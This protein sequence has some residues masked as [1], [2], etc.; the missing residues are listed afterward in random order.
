MAKRRGKRKWNG[1][2]RTFPAELQRVVDF[3]EANQRVSKVI[4]GEYH[5]SRGGRRGSITGSGAGLELTVL[6]GNRSHILHIC[7]AAPAAVEAAL[8]KKF[9]KLFESAV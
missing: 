6:G 9:P 2:G 1:K 3:L 5:Q 7:T 4:P 8:R